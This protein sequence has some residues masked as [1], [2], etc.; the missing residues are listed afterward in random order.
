MMMMIMMMI[1]AMTIGLLRC[2]DDDDP[3]I[4]FQASRPIGRILSTMS[5]RM[6]LR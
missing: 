3:I 4:P 2:S 6:S 5:M 1:A